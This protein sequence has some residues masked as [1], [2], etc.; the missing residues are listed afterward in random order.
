MTRNV[1]MTNLSL[2]LTYSFTR[3]TVNTRETQNSYREVTY[4]PG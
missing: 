4:T 1:L 2:N 3:V